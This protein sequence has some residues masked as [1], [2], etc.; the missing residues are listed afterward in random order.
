M[1]GP[2]G[3]DLGDLMRQSQERMAKLALVREQMAGL[4][5]RAESADGRVAITST[6]EDPLAE[7]RID[8]RALRMGAEDLAAALQETA[9]RARQDLDAQVKKITSRE[10]G[11][12]TD[13]MDALKDQDALKKSLTEMQGMFEQVGQ[14]SQAM[15]E[16]LQRNLGLP[17]TSR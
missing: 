14:R 3:L 6:A 10:Y 17:P 7:I 13:P 2:E 12:T 15:I 4:Q 11:D 9:R 1:F 16:E 5:G 8:P